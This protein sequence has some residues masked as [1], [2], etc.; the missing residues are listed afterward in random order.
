[1]AQLKK[2]KV[3]HIIPTLNRGGAERLLLDIT[4]FYNREQFS[5]SVLVFKAQGDLYNEVVATGVNV[6]ILTKKSKL[7]FY[8]FFQIYQVIKK[9]KPDIV[10]T[11]LG[12]DIYGRLAARM[13]KVPVI[14]STEQNV[15]YDESWFVTLAKRLT[16]RWANGLVALSEA[17]K[18]DASRRYHVSPERY[19]V[20]YSGIDCT[21]YKPLSVPISH[22]YFLL[23]AAGRLVE[24][25]G[26]M[27]L[28]K[29]VQ[30]LIAKNYNI[31]CQIVG[32]G[33]LHSFLTQKIKE[34]GLESV[35][36]LRGVI[37]DMSSFYQSLNAFIMPSVW[38]GLG[39]VVLEAGA[40]GLPVIAARV[41]GLKEIITEG[42]DGWFFTAGDS[43]DLAEK[44]EHVISHPD[45]AH[46]VGKKLAE[47]VRQSFS[48]QKTV[49]EYEALYQQ[50]LTV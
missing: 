28:I 18:K 19:N 13:V 2:V 26:F 34:A 48:I 47:K 43:R 32:E 10:H 8:N 1:M 3:L 7:D 30:Y 21:A 49:A 15:N 23:G 14:I 4:R 36:S 29:A 40:S 16:I 44:I 22:N 11:H 27:Y 20:I 42:V 6:T 24:Q 31:K 46:I 50:Y 41:D 38:E 9:T 35:M 12:G 45:E 5:L 33:P 37:G 39:L 25:K 17:V